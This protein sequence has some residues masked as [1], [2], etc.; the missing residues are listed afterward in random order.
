M[1]SPLPRFCH[2][3]GF[4]SSTSFMKPPLFCILVFLLFLAEGRYKC[5]Y[6]NRPL[7]KTPQTMF[8]LSLIQ[9]KIPNFLYNAPNNEKQGVPSLTRRAITLLFLQHCQLQC[10]CNNT[11]I[12]KMA[13]RWRRP[14]EKEEDLFWVSA[15]RNG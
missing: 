11:S 14:F 7:I 9:V 10:L 3:S 2:F 4:I 8:I 5:R 12:R 6:G 15:S 1:P 13:G